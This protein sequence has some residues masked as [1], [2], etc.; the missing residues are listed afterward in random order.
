MSQL[1]PKKL[2]E[3]NRD[4]YDAIAPLFSATREYNWADVEVLA[5]YIKPGDKVLDLGCGNGRLYQILA[6]KQVLYTGL[7]QSGELIKLAKEKVPEV[8][9]VVGEMTELSFT[10][11]SFDVVFGIASF[12]HIPGSELQL[13]SLQEMKRVLKP[14]GLII[15]TNWNLLSDSAQK[16]I[17]KHGWKVLQESPE[18]GIDVMVPWKNPQGETLGERYYHGFTV[19]ELTSLANAT[20]LQIV[21]L[22]FGHKGERLDQLSGAN[23]ISVFKK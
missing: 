5:E 18:Q 16:N 3:Q 1:E 11:E 9:F 2:I 15:M 4:V 20:D 19:G 21:D 6:K 23:V 17:A 14:G 8:E 7:D 22:Y 13:K 10:A 12:N